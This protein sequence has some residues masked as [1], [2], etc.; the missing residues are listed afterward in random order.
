MGFITRPYSDWV[1]AKIDVMEENAMPP[2]PPVP[3]VLLVPEAAQ[4]P[5]GKA[6][7]PYCGAVLNGDFAFCPSCGKKLKEKQLSTSLFTQISLYVVAILLPPLGYWP[8][9]KYFKNPDPKA[10]KL[11]M[12]LI[13]ITTLSTIITL[14]LTYAFVQSYINDINSALNGTGITPQ[15]ATGGLF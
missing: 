14:W 11:G 6:F 3:P 15:Q 13:I 8:G 4:P 9:I 5:E 1:H 2:V 7:C 12:Y 10:Q